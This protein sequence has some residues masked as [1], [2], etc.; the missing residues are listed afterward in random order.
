MILDSIAIA[1]ENLDRP[2]SDLSDLRPAFPSR[3]RKE[4]VSLVA[5]VQHRINHPQEV[6]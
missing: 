6:I 4:A 1:A 2:S 5:Q 3:D